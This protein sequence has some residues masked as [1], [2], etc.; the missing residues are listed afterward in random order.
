MTE[1]TDALM[2][3]FRANLRVRRDERVLLFTDRIGPKETVTDEDRLRRERLRDVA[4]ITAS[5]GSPMVKHLQY[6]EYPATGMHGKEPPR[7][8]WQAAF[9]VKTIA[10]LDEAGLMRSILM[11]R[12][13]AEAVEAA[14]AII[15][16]HKRYAV[17]A[18]V[19]MSNFST[20]HTA[21]RT[22]L[23][24]ICGTRYAS[25][26]L[27]D[28]SMLD[29]AMLVDW[30]ALKK[31]TAQVARAVRRAVSVEIK[32]PNGTEI[33]FSIKG[34]RVLEDAGDLT[35]TGAF[36]NLPAGEVFMAPVEGTA[37]GRLV[38]EWAP[39]R[40]LARPLTISVKDGLVTD[41]AG[42]EPFRDVLMAKIGERQDNRNI[43]ELGIGTN[44]EARRP[45]NV[46]ESEKIL[47][48]IH[49]A[50]GDNSSFGGKVR[51]PFHMDFVFFR[52]TLTLIDRRGG[53]VILID[54]GRIM[55]N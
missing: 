42:D 35:H 19:A 30:A 36:G 15:N 54:S 41:L 14:R 43:A 39:T 48:T 25:M 16:R 12:A 52:P 13:N 20:S 34:R 10:A 27:F 21:F 5:L 32:S 33:S 51:T 53:R 11:K 47:G 17:H 18:V 55:I 7:A 40:K 28:S 2:A 38:I 29:G 50:L 45:D 44:D 49:I 4:R 1:A 6:L 24:D 22:F 46:L 31:R 37:S 3:I 23:N 8:A 26:P 9:G